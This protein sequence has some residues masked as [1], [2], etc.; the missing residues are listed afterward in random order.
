MKHLIHVPKLVVLTKS[1]RSDSVL[2]SCRKGWRTSIFW[3]SDPRK[4][5]AAYIRSTWLKWDFI[6]HFSSQERSKPNKQTSSILSFQRARLWPFSLHPGDSHSLTQSTGWVCQGAFF[7]TLPQ[8]GSRWN[9]LKIELWSYFSPRF[10]WKD[11]AFTTW[12]GV[13]WYCYDSLRE[14]RTR[15]WMP[16]ENAHEFARNRG[17]VFLRRSWK[18]L[19][20]AKRCIKIIYWSQIS[21]KNTMKIWRSEDLCKS[22]TPWRLR[23]SGSWETFLEI[24]FQQNPLKG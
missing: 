18:R 17:E 5:L 19:H 20:Q 4:Q 7:Q 24:N 16:R 11:R 6:H 23:E 3:W 12:N 9:I 1:G 8:I 15:L 22:V 10:L 13:V 14:S 2:K 21:I